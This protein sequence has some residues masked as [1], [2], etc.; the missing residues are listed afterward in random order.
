MFWS[1]F[2]SGHGKAP[3]NGVGTMIKRFLRR[4]Q[5]DVHGVKL[6]NAKEVV[7]FLRKHLSKRLETSFI[8]VKRPLQRVFWL[9]KAD[10]VWRNSSSFN[11]DPIKGTMKL[12][13]ICAT[14]K[15]NPTTFMVKDLAALP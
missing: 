8:G 4:E 14:N 1:F 9:M 7:N 13:S 2:G 3:H 12:H 11:Y 6:P 5:L 15:K 10:D